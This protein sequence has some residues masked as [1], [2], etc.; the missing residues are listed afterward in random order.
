MAYE[1]LVGPIPD[2]FQIDHL[3]RVRNCVAP[4]HLEAVTQQENLRRGEAGANN[5]IKTHCPHGHEYTPENTLVNRSGSRV[6]VICKRV[7]ARLSARRVRARKRQ[8]LVIP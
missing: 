8:K 5:K 2:G 1:W 6:C 3:C 4:D 7:A